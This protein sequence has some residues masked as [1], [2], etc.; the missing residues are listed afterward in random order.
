MKK[1]IIALLLAVLM[2]V[3][4][5][6]ACAK[7]EEPANPSTETPGTSTDSVSANDG[8]SD[9]DEPIEISIAYEGNPNYPIDPADSEAAQKLAEKFNIKINWL[10]W[11]T[12]QDTYKEKLDL[13]MAGGTAPDIFM[14]NSGDSAKRYVEQELLLCIDD[15][16]DDYPNLKRYLDTTDVR[17]SITYSSDG[18]IYTGVRLYSSPIYFFGLLA[19]QDLIDQSGFEYDGTIESL[20]D[21]MR[22][23]KEETGSYA[24]T[25]RHG[26]EYL[27]NMWGPS[28]GVIMTRLGWSEEEGKYI[29]QGGNDRLY[30]ELVWLNQLYSEGLLDPEYALNTTEMWEEKITTG[31]GSMAIDYFVR[32]EQHTNAVHAENP[33]SSYELR[34]IALPVTKDGY[35]PATVVFSAV[36]TT[37]QTGINVDTKYPELCLQILDYLYSDEAIVEANYGKEGVTFNYVDGEPQYTE[38]IATAENNFTPTGDAIDLQEYR[39]IRIPFFNVVTDANCYALTTYGEYSY[40]GYLMYKQNEWLDTVAPVIPS[41]YCTSDEDA[42]RADI[43]SVLAEYYNATIQDFIDGTRPLTEEEYAKFQTECMDEYGAARWCE[44]M[45]NAYAAW[46]ATK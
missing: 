38:N 23:L 36:D 22:A 6:T 21:L 37:Y 8:T 39:S 45:N 29:F 10:D 18:K 2:V 30:D 27:I 24:F 34:P 16:L 11:G 31:K 14:I 13:N 3:G 1:Q 12:E 26:V 4:M 15:Y 41:G 46:Q 20:T 44:I 33:D 19:R 28:F 43:E 25:F 32:C 7:T 40:D 42:E 9:S 17:N 5:F 35:K